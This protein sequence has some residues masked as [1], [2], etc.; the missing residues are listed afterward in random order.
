[1]R[2]SSPTAWSLTAAASLASLGAASD[3]AGGVVEFD[4]MF[5]RNETYGPGTDD[6]DSMPVLLAIQ[7]AHL[8]THLNVIVEMG[9]YSHPLGL[10]PAVG[11]SRRLKWE[12]LAA[13][14]PYFMIDLHSRK[15]ELNGGEGRWRLEWTVWW[16]S[17]AGISS[18]NMAFWQRTNWTHR[19][20]D[21]TIQ[22]GAQPIDLVAA[23][24]DGKPCGPELGFAVNITSPTVAVPPTASWS[25]DPSCAAVA[26]DSPTPTP[27]PCRVKVS[28]AVAASISS[29]MVATSS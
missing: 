19:Y 7:N 24:A 26:F 29:V 21:F 17:C 22:E 25:G 4:I 1:M 27:N 18:P 15:Y 5:P 6:P 23:S 14:D 11:W 20:V 28:S 9:L 13:H 16:E 3:A 12:N 10:W 2:F 8:A